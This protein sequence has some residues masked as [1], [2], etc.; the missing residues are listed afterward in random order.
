MQ[1]T[2]YLLV[3]HLGTLDSLSP[4]DAFYAKFG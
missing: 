1:K 2:H 4:K 3:L